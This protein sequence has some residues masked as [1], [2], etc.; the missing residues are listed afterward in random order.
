[1]RLRPIKLPQWEI[2]DLKEVAPIP[3]HYDSDDELEIYK[4]ASRPVYGTY[5]FDASDAKFRPDQAVVR[6]RSHLFE[7]VSNKGPYNFLVN[8][9]WSITTLRKSQTKARR[10]EVRYEA[11]PAIAR[12]FSPRPR[13][14][15]FLAVLNGS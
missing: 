10:V 7:E 15:P 2:T 9:G 12:S 6:A 14:P 8:E 13:T 1:M 11:R 5:T 3:V 4:I